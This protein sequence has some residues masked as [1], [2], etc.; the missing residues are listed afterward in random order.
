MPKNITFEIGGKPYSVTWTDPS[1]PTP[2]DID[3]METAVR[4]KYK[5][6]LAKPKPTSPTPGNGSMLRMPQGMLPV[7]VAVKDA[8]LSVDTEALTRSV[9]R[10]MRKAATVQ[11]RPTATAP[12][13]GLRPNQ[14]GVGGTDF[15]VAGITDSINRIIAAPTVARKAAQ[16][17]MSELLGNG[18]VDETVYQNDAPS[19]VGS[20]ALDYATYLLPGVGQILGAAQLA[21]IAGH[22][23]EVGVP[24]ATADLWE[25]SNPM[26]EGINLEDRILRGAAFFYGV[27]H[28]LG[29]AA[30]VKFAV[31]HGMSIKNAKL[32]LELGKRQAK[33]GVK[34]T[35]P[36][37][38]NKPKITGTERPAPKPNIIL[39]KSQGAPTPNPI[40]K[41]KKAFG[42]AEE[43]APAA[44]VEA[45]QPAKPVAPVETPKETAKPAEAAKPETFN[46]TRQNP[47]SRV[48]LDKPI[49][50]PTG[51]KLTSYQWSWKNDLKWSEGKQEFVEARV[52]DWES[53]T[54]NKETG[55]N[56]VHQFYVEMPNGSTQTVSLET[57]AKLLGFGDNTLSS[58]ASSLKTYAKNSMR[59][60]AIADKLAEVDKAT[61][62]AQSK[63]IA[64]YTTRDATPDDGPLVY[65]NGYKII[66]SEGYT[67]S[68]HPE[69][70]NDEQNAAENLKTKI[71]NERV[72]A[73]TGVDNYSI[74][75]MRKEL[76]DLDNRLSKSKVTHASTR[77][78]SETTSKEPINEQTNQVQQTRQ[79][80]S[81]PGSTGPEGTG[82]VNRTQEAGQSGVPTE[83]G[84]GAKEGGVA[85]AVEPTTQETPR[86]EL[87]PKEQTAARILEADAALD[88]A[89]NRASRR[90]RGRQAGSFIINSEVLE[91]LANSARARIDHGVESVKEWLGEVESKYGKSNPAF[92][93]AVCNRSDEIWE[94]A[95]G[96]PV[97]PTEPVAETPKPAKP[98]PL[99]GSTESVVTGDK[100]KAGEATTPKKRVRASETDPNNVTGAR[101]SL[102]DQ[103]RLPGTTIEQHAKEGEAKLNQVGESGVMDAVHASNESGKPMT[104]AEASAAQIIQNNIE[105]RSRALE[106]KGITSGAEIKKLIAQKQAVNR[107]L[108]IYGHE[109]NTI[110]TNLQ[111]ARD[112]HG[113]LVNFLTA[114][115]DA[116][117][118]KLTPSEHKDYAAMYQQ[119]ADLQAK[120][121]AHEATKTDLEKQLAA[122]KAKKNIETLRTENAARSKGRKDTAEQIA[123]RKAE[124]LRKGFR[125]LQGQ[126]SS[127]GFDRLAAAAPH[128]KDA[129][130]EL[131]KQGKVKLSD[132][133]DSLVTEAKVAGI[134][135]TEREV[136]GMLAGEYDPKPNKAK[137]RVESIRTQ[138][139]KELQAETRKLER[140]V[141]ATEYVE[142]Q[143]KASMDRAQNEKIKVE[144]FAKKKAAAADAKFHADQARRQLAAL[145]KI[146]AA[147][148]KE[149]NLK[150]KIEMGE[151]KLKAR[152]ELQQAR[153][154][155]AKEW[156]NSI[157]GKREALFERLQAAESALMSPPQIKTPKPK[158][159]PELLDLT[160][161]LNAA[162]FKA[163]QLQERVQAKADYDLLTQ[164]EKNK[165]AANQLL[166]A[167]RT[168]LTSID[169][170]AMLRQGLFL[171]ISHARIIPKVI[172][173]QYHAGKS[174]VNYTQVMGDVMTNPYFDKALNAKLDLGGLT[175]RRGGEFFRSDLLSRPVK[176]KGRDV[177][178]FA[179]SE[180][181][182]DAAIVSTRMQAFA[183]E[184]HALEKFHGRGLDIDELKLVA[185]HINQVSG[186]G[187]GPTAQHLKGLVGSNLFAPG[188][189]VSK[190]Q[191][192]TGAALRK[193]IAHGKKTGDYSIAKVQA[194]NYAKFLASAGA[195]AYLLSDDHDLKSSRFLTKR[196]GNQRVNL[197][198]GLQQP[199]IMFSQLAF[200]TTDAKGKHHPPDW[201]GTLGNFATG[202]EGVGLRVAQ[203][204]AE[205]KSYGKK[206]DIHT[207]EGAGNIAKSMVV[208]ISIQ[209][210]QDIWS[211]PKL[212]TIEKAALTTAVYFGVDVNQQPKGK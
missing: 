202:K 1:D 40:Q 197:M 3:E 188:Y 4:A 21:Q 20:T 32:S 24:Q 27:K 48:D 176:V 67:E 130:V 185:E 44:P 90:T 94:K 77:A 142:Q 161:K 117:G 42:V 14:Q 175:G 204:I 41:I 139:Q 118:E 33:T 29:E 31:D 69:R 177:N 58:T 169:R 16:S 12:V 143:A 190:F 196:I 149:W 54:Q 101:H 147:A 144:E 160:I 73:Q 106:A 212:S 198:G 51:A 151:A 136:L 131:G 23:A 84:G 53:S 10:G 74:K 17:G 145:K 191:T 75:R 64:Q 199:L 35:A 92:V 79:E 61:V 22:A 107:A 38:S 201:R 34:T 129:A 115:Q 163:K 11:T 141:K 178:A 134:K 102:M 127:M 88:Q 83:S 80:T 205:K 45:A 186:S 171:A 200:G 164:G 78:T 137:E 155:Y 135:V 49:V 99:T 110:G 193:A 7:D 123:A 28:I 166:G 8:P 36:E 208:P 152:K 183:L 13:E 82:G 154:E 52:S 114:M 167:S 113:S 9:R 195:A 37:V 209:N 108:K 206:T 18:P 104:H 132:V 122:E 207:L 65:R 172:M 47:V 87:T 187:T 168:A 138:A 125:A 105:R 148:D 71:I 194:M 210:A 170:S 97:A 5:L 60:S 81:Q 153:A 111:Q 156:K 63:P 56:V 211:D 146:Q 70:L 6:P 121:D 189:L 72:K 50:G 66:E 159:P 91:A 62:D 128:F 19:R 192:A 30:A 46:V 103:D 133:V 165:E 86:R 68:F 95:G 76:I 126:A 100:I 184:V 116:K 85:G 182:Y 93:A 39:G 43:P 15:S 96:K 109:F 203:S 89:L 158:L 179:R 25:A 173:D 124:A 57:A 2:A 174:E 112:M 26:A 157:H 181:A 120:V 150:D 162:K 119:I 55:K 59:R 140:K 180:R 98:T